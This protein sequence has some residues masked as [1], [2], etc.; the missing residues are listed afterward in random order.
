MSRKHKN[1]TTVQQQQK[2]W[3]SE[4]EEGKK[5]EWMNVWL[6][7]CCW[8]RTGMKE[9]MVGKR[10]SVSIKSTRE[11]KSFFFSIDSA[12]IELIHSFIHW[13]I[14]WWWCLLRDVDANA[15]ADVSSVLIKR[16]RIILVIKLFS[17]LYYYYYYYTKANLVFWS[18]I[19]TKKKLYIG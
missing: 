9:I 4:Q 3:S 13:Y 17:S 5:K 16:N 6:E 19:K 15:D 12:P 11:K 18:S 7:W 8:A 2:Q 14:F 1:K 10:A